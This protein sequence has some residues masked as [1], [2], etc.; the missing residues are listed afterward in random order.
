[1]LVLLLMGS[2]LAYNDCHL[3]A[4]K[5]DYFD[6]VT[7]D[8]EGA[9]FNEYCDD[10]NYQECY[11]YMFRGDDGLNG[12]DGQNGLDGIDGSDGRDGKSAGLSDLKRWLN[13]NF[14]DFLK[15]LF[16]SLDIFDRKVDGLELRLSVLEA[17]TRDLDYSSLDL[18]RSLAKQ[19]NRTY[20]VNGIACAVNGVCVQGK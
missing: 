6:C 8:Y 16:V 14:L 10:E 13:S 5:K 20:S 4:C 19:Y 7:K 11:Y 15:T 2:V 12:Q 3:K 17:K 1:M 18:A 9:C